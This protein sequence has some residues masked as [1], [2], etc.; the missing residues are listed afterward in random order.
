MLSTGGDPRYTQWPLKSADT[1]AWEWVRH[2][3]VKRVA[4]SI[5]MQDNNVISFLCLYHARAAPTR[6]SEAMSHAYTEIFAFTNVETQPGR[7]KSANSSISLCPI[8][9][10][11]K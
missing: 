3:R 6:T 8:W 7:W 9:V 4:A 5:V 11:Q 10:H 1:P 2:T